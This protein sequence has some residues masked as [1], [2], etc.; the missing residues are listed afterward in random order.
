MGRFTLKTLGRGTRRC[1]G[2]SACCYVSRLASFEKPAYTQCP[3]QVGRGCDIYSDRPDNCQTFQCGWTK[4]FGKDRDRPDRLGVFLTFMTTPDFGRIARLH[5]VGD[6]EFDDE[7][8]IS[9]VGRAQLI[10]KH[11]VVGV[12]QV[13]LVI[14]GG[15]TELVAKYRQS[16]RRSEAEGQDTGFLDLAPDYPSE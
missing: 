6:V 15:P 11:I 10:E 5:M 13:G 12:T 16:L 3:H 1:D 8:V 2:C 4:G 9:F 14:L 7:N